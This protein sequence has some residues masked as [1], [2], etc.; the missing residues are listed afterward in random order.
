LTRDEEAD[1][2]ALVKR[3]SR[4][5]FRVAYAVL[6]NCADAEEAVQESFL[7]LHRH[8]GWQQVDNERAF[9]ARIAWRTAVDHLRSKRTASRLQNPQEL[10]SEMPSLHPGPE[11]TLMAAD[12]HALIHSLIDTLPDDL[13]IP[14][15]LSSTQDLNSREIATILEIPEGTVRTRLQRARLLLRQKLEVRQFRN[16]ETRHA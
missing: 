7:K 11:Q 2:T 9:L 16:Q 10:L 15:V 5:L 12:Q 13:R 14:L 4:F 8:G 6:L 3:Q 1:F